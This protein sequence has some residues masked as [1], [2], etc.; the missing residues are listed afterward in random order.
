MSHE[1]PPLE[2]AKLRR[3]LAE[4]AAELDEYKHR[5]ER[6]QRFLS[7]RP[8]EMRRVGETELRFE[9]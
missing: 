9:E 4:Q 6:I 1:E 8:D 3:A 2:L 5:C 7:L